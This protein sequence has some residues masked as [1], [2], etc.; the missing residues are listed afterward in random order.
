VYKLAKQGIA[1]PPKVVENAIQYET[2][3]GSEAYGVSSE[4]SDMDVYGF[5]IPPLD[6]IFPYLRGEIPGF[7]RQHQRF[8]QYQEH[9]LEWNEW[10]YDLSIYSI[11][12][13][14]HLCLE[15]NPNMID[16]LYTPMNCVLHI[17][18]LGTIVRDN[19]DLF[20]HK[21]AYHKFR[22]YAYSQLAKID[23]KERTQGKRKELIEEFG[24]D[25][26]FAYHVI[27]LLDECEQILVEGTIDLQ[28]SKEV[29]KSVRRGEWTLEQV[30]D[31]FTRNEKRLEE[32]YHTSKLPYSPDE[33]TIKTVLVYVLEEHFG[34]LSKVVS[35][36]NRE[37]EAYSME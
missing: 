30:R 26:K 37:R 36:Q 17:T 27:R 20:L 4:S 7:G 1:H 25:V 28:R 3:M 2:I 8:E 6:D 12:K 19:R 13:F 23:N 33:G 22:G 34:S 15:N 14:F 32:M 10:Q 24:Y 29:L 35:V 18:R 31:Y 5:C 9:H 21:G 16:S 11:V